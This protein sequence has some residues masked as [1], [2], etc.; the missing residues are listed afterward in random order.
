M[1]ILIIILAFTSLCFADTDSEYQ[2]KEDAA[3]EATL[4]WLE[5]IDN[6]EYEKSWE[7]AAEYFRQ[8]IELEQWVGALETA[9]APHGNIISREMTS[10][11]YTTSL[12][13]AP[14]SE[15][16]FIQFE[17]V[18]EN[19]EKGFETLTPMLQEN[20]EWRISGYYI[21]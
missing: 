1:V 13:N 10:I 14:E 6:G 15:Y 2:A 8:I 4:S 20:G 16:F 19:K 3:L 11:D 17:S 18:F 5:L 7:E 21:R 12:P 9:R